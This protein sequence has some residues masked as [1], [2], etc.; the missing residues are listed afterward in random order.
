MQLRYWTITLHCMNTLHSFWLQFF[1]VLE[2]FSA[3]S[4]DWGYTNSSFIC[5]SILR[6]NVSGF[7]TSYLKHIKYLSVKTQN[8]NKIIM[9]IKNTVSKG[10]LTIYTLFYH[11]LKYI[12]LS[13]S[14]SLPM[15][16]IVIIYIFTY[17]STHPARCH[18]L[19]EVRTWT[20]TQNLG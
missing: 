4:V 2:N 14:I 8:S 19:T 10:L 15:F 17:W 3:L 5:L 1:F 13:S 11:F 6:F 16:F 12:E 18:T 20:W 9:T 7:K